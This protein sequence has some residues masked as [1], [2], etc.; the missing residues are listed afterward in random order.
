M[1]FRSKILADTI[2]DNHQW[3]Q[4][5]MKYENYFKTVRWYTAG[6][7]MEMN[8]SGM[9]FLSNYVSTKSQMPAFQPIPEMQTL[10]LESYRANNYVGVG[11]R[12]I[13]NITKDFDVRLE[14]YFYQPFQ[15]V[16][17]NTKYKATYGDAFNKRYLIG[18]L[19]AVYQSPVGPISLA[20]NY[21]E[22]RE[23]PLSVVFHIGYFLFNKKSIQ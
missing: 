11:L 17:Q 6:I 15:E 20:L 3:F 4:L 14:G 2:K 9:P 7:Y 22:E 10:F 19:N 23:K 12:N 5:L 18:T 16:L 21:I 8:F 1:L 13:F